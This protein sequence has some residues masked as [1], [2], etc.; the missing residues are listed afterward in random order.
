M[1]T[2]T[3]IV[4]DILQFLIIL[5]SLISGLVLMFALPAGQKSGRLSY[6]GITRFQWLD[7]HNYTSL[8]FVGLVLIHLVLHWSWIKCIPQMF[9]NK[10]KE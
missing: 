4:I 6:W 9:S 3:N 5:P 2:K 1:R 10:Y 7:I 8:I